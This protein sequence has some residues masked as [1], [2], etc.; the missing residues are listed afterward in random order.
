MEL[1]VWQNLMFLLPLLLAVLYL[2]VLATGGDGHGHHDAGGHDATGHGHDGHHD[3]H[4]E[5]ESDL[6]KVLGL[7]GIGRV[8]LSLVLV[9]MLV[10]W[11]GAGLIT[12]QIVGTNMWFVSAG[13]A[14]LA[15]LLCTGVISNG[16]GRLLQ[17]R[18]YGVAR[19]ALV[20]QK[21][22]TTVPITAECGEARLTDSTG[23]LRDL[24]VRVGPGLAQIPADTEVVL[25]SYDRERGVFIVQRVSR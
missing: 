18:S 17:T 12:N 4:H 22:R 14:A 6:S 24:A 11:G 25:E 5:S 19:E 2:L 23:T 7:I 10:T 21:A 20:K 8:P 13:I 15:A 9:T 1:L 16:A 3:A